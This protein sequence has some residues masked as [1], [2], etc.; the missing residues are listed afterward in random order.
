MAPNAAPLA[1][2]LLFLCLITPLCPYLYGGLY[3]GLYERAHI[4]R[5]FSRRQWHGR[6]PARPPGRGAPGRAARQHTRVIITA[7]TA[8]YES[9]TTGG[10]GYKDN[11]RPR[12]ARSATGSRRAGTLRRGPSVILPPPF[13]FVWGIPIGKQ[14]TVTNGSAPSSMYRVRVAGAAC[15]AA[16]LTALACMRPPGAGRVIPDCHFAVPLSHFIPGFLLNSVA[17]FRK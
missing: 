12:R 6:G 14:M 3:G 10:T 17:V 1:G 4:I 11:A 7:R 5:C 9:L 2:S 16:G 8:R 13:S 15:C